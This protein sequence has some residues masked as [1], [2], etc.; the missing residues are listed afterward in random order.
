MVGVGFLIGGRHKGYYNKVGNK[1][2]HRVIAVSNQGVTV[3]PIAKK[4]FQ[5]Y[6]DCIYPYS[7]DGNLADYFYCI[8]HRCFILQR[9]RNALIGR[10]DVFLKKYDNKRK[11]LG[12]GN[13]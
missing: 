2:T 10:P 5:S 12:D 4:Q 8:V 3:A 13:G 11:Q 7:Y 9:N 6:Q 1:I